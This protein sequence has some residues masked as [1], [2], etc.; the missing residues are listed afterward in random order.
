MQ[1]CRVSAASHPITVPGAG[2]GRPAAG[3]GRAVQ[4]GGSGAGL[5]GL[6]L[7]LRLDSH[8]GRVTP[9]RAVAACAHQQEIGAAAGAE[10]VLLDTRTEQCDSPPPWAFP[11]AGS[12][13][14]AEPRA[15]AEQTRTPVQ[16]SHGGTRTHGPLCEHT[17]SHT[18]TSA[19]SCRHPRSHSWEHSA[20][21][22]TRLCT[23]HTC[24][25]ICARTHSWGHTHTR[26]STLT[27]T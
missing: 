23:Q 14:G 9:G 26:V 2:W 11:E 27:V 3:P 7:L 5:G 18:N 1:R 8:T 19:R 25:Y 24:C 10:E 20:H 6:E 13:Q 17:R 22:C 21:G 4:V 16:H 15:L 12:S